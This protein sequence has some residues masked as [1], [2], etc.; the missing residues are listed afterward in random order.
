MGVSDRDYKREMSLGGLKSLE[1]S[2]SVLLKNQ[3]LQLSVEMSSVILQIL[4]R[5]IRLPFR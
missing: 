4:C 5:E 3:E 2:Q 1:R